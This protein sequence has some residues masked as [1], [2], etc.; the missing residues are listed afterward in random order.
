MWIYYRTNS[1]TTIHSLSSELKNL[2]AVITGGTGALGTMIAQKLL[3]A[4]CRIAIPHATSGSA[5]RL[6]P[7]LKTNRDVLVHLADFS[8]E[9]E[10]AAFFEKVVGRFGTVDILVNAAGG[11]VGGKTIADTTLQDW[12]RAMAMNLTTT[13]LA[14]RAALRI[15]MPRGSGRIVNIAAM[16][17]LEPV[18][19]KGAYAVSKGGVVTLTETIA[20]EVRGTGI[21]VN[22][23]APSTILTEANKQW[24][25]K[26]DES[27]WVPPEEIASL[28]TYLCSSEGRS[29]SGNTIKIYGGV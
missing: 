25:T 6:S 19:K 1:T 11:Y 20:E 5:D 29:M 22:A 16:T 24:M 7:D 15:M 26:G 13:F 27:K 18:A 12:E 4:G 3:S 10:V 2:V 17:A 23:I 8:L 9:A 14:C 21:T 28:V